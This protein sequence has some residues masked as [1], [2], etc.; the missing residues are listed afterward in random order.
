LGSFNQYTSPWC[1]GSRI[2]LYDLEKIGGLPI[3]GDIYEEFLS[4]N[5]DLMDAEK[6]LPVVLELLRTHAELCHF[7]KSNHVYWNWWL[8]HFY[9]GEVT[10]GAFGKES[11]KRTLSGPP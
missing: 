7:Y 3:L 10:W 2:S 8:D 9:R 4:R 5:E 11:E 6:F 1:W